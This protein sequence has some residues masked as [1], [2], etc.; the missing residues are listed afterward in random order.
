MADELPY[1]TPSAEQ[2]AKINKLARRKLS[3]SEIFV[4]PSKL[5]GDM[6]IPDRYV[7]LTK[8]LLDVFAAN[9]NKG[10]S[11]LLDHSWKNGGFLG[12]G[13]RPKPAIPYGR[14]FESQFG[15]PTEEGE[16]LSLNGSTYMLRG[17]D[18]DSINTDGL[19]RSIEGGTLFDTSI[20]FG[21]NVGI[22]SIC[23]NDI[24][25]SDDCPHYPGETYKIKDENG[26][27][28]EVLCWIKANPPGGLYE[29]SGVFD[30]AYPGSLIL[31]ASAGD[32]LENEHGIYEVIMDLKDIDPSKPIIATYSP[33]VGLLTMVKKGNHQK[34]FG[35]SGL[36]EH[37]KASATSRDNIFAIGDKLGISRDQVKNIANLVLEGDENNMSKE[38]MAILTK[39]GIKLEEG[40]EY[41]EAEALSMV[42]A[43]QKKTQ[44]QIDAAKVAANVPAPVPFMAQQQATEKLGKEMSADDVLKLAKEGQNY[45]DELVKEALKMGVRAQGESFKQETWER[46][47]A[48]MEVQDIKDTMSTWE[49]QAKAA[50]PGGR[51]TDPASGQGQAKAEIPDEAYKVK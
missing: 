10:V 16:T 8:E 49:A 2:L 4:F 6:I 51:Q 1:G 22:C 18:I 42:E 40:K 37:A 12:V 24:F 26:S 44:D 30:G 34:K 3:E 48:L 23:G 36:I 19:I 5:A 33:R 39:L 43:M 21:F 7:Q 14:T 28:K 46:N 13:G 17:V 47:F 41:T 25:H 31:S 9:A 29:H 27:E 32:V 38:T 20:G 45:R 15:P 35:V 11:F 50:I